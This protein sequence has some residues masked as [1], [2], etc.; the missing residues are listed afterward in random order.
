MTMV[1]GGGPDKDKDWDTA[2]PRHRQQPDLLHRPVVTATDGVPG[3]PVVVLLRAFRGTGTQRQRQGLTAGGQAPSPTNGPPPKP[4]MVTRGPPTDDGPPMASRRLLAVAGGFYNWA[5]WDVTERGLVQ[6][7]ASIAAA[8]H[9]QQNTWGFSTCFV[10]RALTMPFALPMTF[11]VAFVRPLLSG[12]PHPP[13]LGLG[14]P[15]VKRSLCVPHIGLQFRASV[16]PPPPSGE[17][18]AP[19]QSNSRCC[20]RNFRNRVLLCPLETRPPIRAT[21]GVVSVK[22]L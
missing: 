4:P 21:V 10:T 1:T 6:S 2:A 17:S 20:F 16:T 15:D 13:P 12:T 8:G 22:I 18:N 11:W 5:P 19:R 7:L 9:G 3:T 14:G